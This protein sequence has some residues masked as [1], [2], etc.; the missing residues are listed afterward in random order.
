MSHFHLKH[1]ILI[2]HLSYP[3]LN[4]ID[5]VNHFFTCFNLSHLIFNFFSSLPTP[6]NCPNYSFTRL[7]FWELQQSLCTPGLVT[8]W[9]NELRI[10]HGGC[11]HSYNFFWDNCIVRTIRILS[12]FSYVERFFL[13]WFCLPTIVLKTPFPSR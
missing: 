11:A 7:F 9:A 5:L 6:R 8:P 1:Y 10:L 13:H 12:F 3:R 4:S 2:Y